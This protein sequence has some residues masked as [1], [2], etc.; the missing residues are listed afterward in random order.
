MSNIQDNTLLLHT[1][2]SQQ[3]KLN[4]K[5]ETRM[6]PYGNFVDGMFKSEHD[7]ASVTPRR[8]QKDPASNNGR[9]VLPA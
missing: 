3:L 8:D 2:H 5:S 9:I 4:E 1:A 6:L 7:L